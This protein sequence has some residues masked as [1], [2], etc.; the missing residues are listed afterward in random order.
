VARS[1]VRRI[2]IIRRKG[3]VTVRVRVRTTGANNKSTARRIARRV[4]KR[5][6]RRILRKILRRQRR[7][8]NVTRK[9][10]NVRRIRI[11]VV[12][13]TKVSGFT[14]KKGKKRTT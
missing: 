14:K 12:K 5:T 2:R 10:N 3:R 7:R 4:A 9:L 1:R 11:P 13:V 6:A 8:T